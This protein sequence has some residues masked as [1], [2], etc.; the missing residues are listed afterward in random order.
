MI[1]KKVKIV[2]AIIAVLVVGIFAC[3]KLFGDKSAGKVTISVVAL[4]G[5]TV[6]E[7]TIKYMEEDTLAGLVEK[8]F[9]NVTI[10]DGFLYTIETLTT[11][12]DW[13]TYICLYVNGEMSQVGILEVVLADGMTVSFVDTE[14]SW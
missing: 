4:D 1:S 10:T 7:K 12:A 8:N 13:S 5:T 6:T 3:S 2:V 14:L 11:P 9:E